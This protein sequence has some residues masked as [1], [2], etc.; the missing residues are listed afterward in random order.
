MSR[1]PTSNVQSKMSQ[2]LGT[3]P[4]IIVKI[5][6]PSGTVYYADKS[7]TIGAITALGR[8]LSCSEIN[9]SQ[10]ADSSAQVSSVSL[11]LSDNDGSL[12]IIWNC[13]ILEKTLITVYSHFV[14][15]ASTDLLEVFK[16]HIINPVKWSEGEAILNI[17]A[18][19]IINA[20]EVG[21]APEEG[22]IENLSNDAIDKAW[23]LCFGTVLHVPCTKVRKHLTGSLR[24]GINN[25][26]TSFLVD[27]GKD[28]PQ[29]TIL[30]IRIGNIQF[31]G[32]FEDDTFFVSSLNDVI[33]SNVE[34]ASRPT[35][36]PDYN[37]P[38]VVWLK[39]DENLVQQFCMVHDVTYGWMCN[40]CEA[41]YG[42]KA[43]FLKPWRPNNTNLGVCL[44]S[45]HT[46]TET[47][48]AP[49]IGWAVTFVL[50]AS[51]W[52]VVDRWIPVVG[53][54]SIPGAFTLYAGYPV[55][56]CAEYNELYVA[57]LI[58]SYEILDVFAYRTDMYNQRIFAPVPSHYYIK[59]LNNSLD[60][61]HPTTIELV[62]PLTWYPYE[63]WEDELY[64]SLR[65]SKGNNP[66]D[67]IKYIITT[68]TNLA[69]DNASYSAIR[70]KTAT[71]AAN[72]AI[73]DKKDALQ[74]CEDIAWQ[75]RM[76]L[77]V[78][79]ETVY[80]RYLSEVPATDKTLTAACTELKTLQLGFTNT[81]ELITKIKAVWYLDYSGRTRSKKELI[82]D[83]GHNYKTNEK[84]IEFYIY[85]IE[86]LV[87][88]S[89][90]WWG[91]R[92]S[93]SWRTTDSKCFLEGLALE[94]FDVAN[95]DIGVLSQN[96]IRGQVVTV[97]HNSDENSISVS[98]ILASKAGDIDGT[99]QPIEDLQF[100]KGD[101]TFDITHA[102]DIPDPGAGHEEIDYILPD[103]G[104][105][106]D[107]DDDGKDEYH[108]VIKE[109]PNEIQRGVNTALRIEIQDIT[110]KLVRESPSAVLHLTSSDGSDALSTA[111]IQFVS[112]VW[113]TTSLQITGGSGAD[114]GSLTVAAHNYQS[115]TAEFAI[116]DE[117]GVLSWDTYPTSVTRGSVFS[118]A[119]SGGTPGG[120]LEIGLNSSDVADKLYNASGLVTTITLDGYGE[121]T[122]DDWY[123]NGGNSNATG[124]LV[125]HDPARLFADAT[126][127]AFPI[128]GKTGKL[129]RDRITLTDS[130]SADKNA[131]QLV[132][133]V[134]AYIDDETPFALRV[135]YQDVNGDV[136]TDFNG[137]IEIVL[138]DHVDE[139]LIWLDGGPDAACYGHTLV[140]F[141]TAGVWTFA[142]CK[143]DIDPAA[144]SPAHFR[145]GALYGELITEETC[146][147]GVPYLSV[148]IPESIYRGV[149]FNLVLQ[150]KNHDG[151]NK[152]DYTPDTGVTF[153][154]TSS[155][156]ED[157]I[158]P[159]STNAT[160]WS[161]GAKTIE[162]SISGGTGS[163]TL[164]LTC[165]D[166]DI[167]YM[168]G[169]DT[170]NLEDAF[171]NWSDDGAAPANM[172][173]IEYF[174]TKYYG[175]VPSTK[176]FYSRDSAGTWTEIATLSDTPVDLVTFGSY[177]Y[178][179]YTTTG[180]NFG[181]Y[182]YSVAGGVETDVSN[183]VQNVSVFHIGHLADGY[184]YTGSGGAENDGW[185][186]Y[187][188]PGSWSLVGRDYPYIPG[189][190]PTSQWSREILDSAVWQGYRYWVGQS[191]SVSGFSGTTPVNGCDVAHNRAYGIDDVNSKIYYKTSRAATKVELTIMTGYNTPKYCFGAGNKIFIR[192][193]KTSDN[194][195]CLLGYDGSTW[196]SEYIFTTTL[197]NI[198]H[199]AKSSVSLLVLMS[200][201][202]CYFK[203]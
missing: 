180:A 187:R 178:I 198:T 92:M 103:G 48:G 112:G 69:I 97:G 136:I 182:K 106:P 179:S 37:N 159:T 80:F 151:T 190:M 63:K 50:E 174:G 166:N 175:I 24:V 111:S 35:D 84:E 183:L 83:P 59:N 95:Y 124:S 46:I 4:M 89:L 107:S 60:G 125:A 196:T 129:V 192:A 147:I 162:C 39:N 160:G 11:S 1:S 115:A 153:V 200:D 33:N 71:Y 155:D 81:D 184:L 108:F 67:I 55:V 144:V 57:N 96:A 98:S 191:S 72:F 99:Y 49:R 17:E 101:P 194:K 168:T 186:Y 109:C 150:A 163:D 64:V 74:L 130:V 44:N 56:L 137:A 119:I 140:A 30:H 54:A 202:H 169:T 20:E 32:H 15:L 36:D 189:G 104:S 45:N 34:L 73:F 28:F 114:T 134:P 126:T 5:D 82:Y 165:T 145:S 21:Y 149:P 91:Y 164:S 193:K 29:D 158:T 143:V 14:G 41:Q 170:S 121:Y 43:Y 78:R 173:R 66:A 87:K 62:Q 122:A 201:G 3:E 65:S 61:N 161:N 88:L 152:T 31:T 197:I 8:L 100:W 148:T 75:S 2:A 47:A 181:V 113:T 176:K 156:N 116:V 102:L 90:Y 138:T 77:M 195:Y 16:G 40:R 203:G 141:M 142:S 58:P 128:T 139:D 154:L 167:S 42:R 132:I 9:T 120:A 79:N 105:D 146:P 7:I 22:D 26:A 51:T 52:Y 110:G 76:A 6:W 93:N 185:H 172:T 117:Q 53:N 25:K 85:N 19:S 12:K 177:L 123:V 38:S 133:T 13:D 23:P 86:D 157:E 70:T 118:V 94:S 188:G 199:F 171:A 68:Y 27:G 135:E 18:E 10:K 127:P 131:N